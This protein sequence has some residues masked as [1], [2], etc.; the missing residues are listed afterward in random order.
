MLKSRNTDWP[1]GMLV[2]KVS[3]R[4]K[5]AKKRKGRKKGKRKEYNLTIFRQQEENYQ[6]TKAC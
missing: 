2:F 6:P 4:C 1:I 5:E 3:G